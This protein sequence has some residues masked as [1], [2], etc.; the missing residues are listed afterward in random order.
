M[1]SKMF[2]IGT[3]ILTCFLITACNESDAIKDKVIS[4]P[5]S[6]SNAGSTQSPPATPAP[7]S[8][9]ISLPRDQ[10]PNKEPTYQDGL[11]LGKNNGAL[12]GARITEKTI[13]LE[14]CSAIGKMENALIAVNQSLRMPV[15]M[16]TE[17]AKG[18]Y[19]GY[20]V[21]LRNSIQSSRHKCNLLKMN[22]GSSMGSLFGSALCSSAN[23]NLKATK[24]IE[25]VPVY[26]GWSDSSAVVLD[27]CQKSMSDELNK[28]A[29]RDIKLSDELAVH[30]KA[31]CSDE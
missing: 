28:C 10:L 6:S 27:E 11:V 30:I 29:I 12:I 5:G 4:Q 20:L 7:V 8:L 26:K 17:F 24:E 3:V 19:T 21:S 13:G 31:T 14:G 23:E 16:K 15:G 2:S 25:M 9:P 22:S 1:K 18:Y